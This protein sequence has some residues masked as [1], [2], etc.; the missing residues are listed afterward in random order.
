MP[1]LRMRDKSCLGN[2]VDHPTGHQPNQPTGGGPRCQAAF[3]GQNKYLNNLYRSEVF[4][5]NMVI[6]EW[7]KAGPFTKATSFVDVWISVIFC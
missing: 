1:M 3:S 4:K 7:K 6:F 2:S 5:K